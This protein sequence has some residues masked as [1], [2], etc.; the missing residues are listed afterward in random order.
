MEAEPAASVRLSCHVMEPP[1]PERMRFQE[2]LGWGALGGAERGAYSEG[3]GAPAPP[4]TLPCSSLASKL[5][6][7]IINWYEVNR[8]LP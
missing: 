5:Y 4:T 2:L 3:V 6:P 8:M 7:F 1:Q